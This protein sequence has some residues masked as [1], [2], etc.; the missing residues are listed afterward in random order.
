MVFASSKS[1]F[2]GDGVLNDQ[3]IGTTAAYQRVL[4]QRVPNYGKVSI[5][6]GGQILT[7]E[8]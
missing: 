7:A 2:Y 5:N 1:Q 4:L 3:N 8:A 6:A